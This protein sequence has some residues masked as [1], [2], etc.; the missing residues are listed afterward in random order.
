ML[1]IFANTALMDKKAY[2][3]I[4]CILLA[5]FGVGIILLTGDWFGV[6]NIWPAAT[7][8]LIAYL[9]ATAIASVF[10]MVYEFSKE[11]ESEMVMVGNE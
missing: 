2:G 7:S 1:A 11:E 3:V 6:K 4:A 5:A 8:V 10:F 9:A